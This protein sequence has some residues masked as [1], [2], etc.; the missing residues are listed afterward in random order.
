MIARLAVSSGQ[1]LAKRSS[2]DAS[3]KSGQS[4]LI[5]TNHGARGDMLVAHRLDTR[6]PLAAARQAS[7]SGENPRSVV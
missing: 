5:K 2:R 1:D 6:R 4:E 3:S 7:G